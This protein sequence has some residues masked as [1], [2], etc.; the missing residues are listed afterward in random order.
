MCDNTDNSMGRAAALAKR[1]V[2]DGLQSRTPTGLTRAD[3]MK[4]K[5]GRIVSKRKHAAGVRQ[6]AKLIATNRAA[7]KFTRGRARQEFVDVDM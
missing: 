2:W 5:Q 3:L 4:N 1:R 6:M 7:P